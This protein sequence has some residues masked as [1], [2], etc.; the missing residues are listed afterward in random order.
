MPLLPS[1]VDIVAVVAATC[2][3]DNHLIKFIFHFP[4]WNSEIQLF[5]MVL[6]KMDS[7]ESDESFVF[8]LN[9]VRALN[10]SKLNLIHVFLIL[11][12]ECSKAEPE[13]IPF[14]I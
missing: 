7:I 13:F 10:Q 11:F 6:T 14:S 9:D 2:V 5:E 3:K 1:L 12:L 4:L 8:V